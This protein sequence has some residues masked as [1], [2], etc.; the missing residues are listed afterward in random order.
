MTCQPRQNGFLTSPEAWKGAFCL[1][2]NM[3]CPIQDD[4]LIH[5]VH[6]LLY[7]WISHRINT[8]GLR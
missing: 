8:F 4:S 2:A 7:P 6:C 3:W 5:F 1:R